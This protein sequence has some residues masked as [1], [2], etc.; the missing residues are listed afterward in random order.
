MKKN[1]VFEYLL[2]AIILAC[3]FTLIF[4][5]ILAKPVSN[6]D[7]LWNYNTARQIANGLI[8][9]KDISMITTPLLPTVIAIILKLTTDELIVFRIIT[10]VIS[11]SLI[12]M[13]YLIFKQILKNKLTCVILTG[14]ILYIYYKNFMLD[15]NFVVLLIALI[16][17]YIELKKLEKTP[18]VNNKNEVIENIKINN[19][20]DRKIKD[21][22]NKKD[23]NFAVIKDNRYNFIIGLLSG[24]AICTKQTLGVFVAI[25][26]LIAPMLF[27]NNKENLKQYI[28]NA[29]IRILGMLIPVMAF[30]IFLI[31]SGSLKYF[32][33][34]AILG[35]KTFS[36]SISYKSLINS[37]EKMLKIF[38][39]ILPVFLMLILV[40]F[41]INSTSKKKK[42]PIHILGRLEI[43]TVYSAIMLIVLYPI[44]DKTHFYIAMLPLFIECIYV[45]IEIIKSIYFKIKYKLKENT[46]QNLEN[47]KHIRDKISKIIDFTI[48]ASIILT[49]VGV[50]ANYTYTELNDYIGNN[51]RNKNIKHYENII[52]TDYIESRIND[53]KELIKSAERKEIDVIILDAEASVIDIPLDRYHKNYD[54]FLKGNIGKDGEE[55]IIKDIQNSTKCIY[56]TKKDKKKLNWQSP[57]QAINYVEENL[58]KLGELNLYNLYYKK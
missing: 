49:I 2:Y 48:R 53:V 7:E 52:V 58:E 50:G 5:R 16:I 33:D 40:A 6:L 43:M 46:K 4:S 42:I 56:L 9:Y 32:I 45:I 29:L 19:I 26:T 28:K 15:Y 10:A 39:I 8:P 36:N 20:E 57:R 24:I 27:V 55:G 31:I 54:M 41:I 47:S 35:I 18:I 34:Y 37:K 51:N 1:K 14:F 23:L 11:T 21:V 30:V 13:T 17:E 22:S 25:G 12:F 44:A 3:V 38:A